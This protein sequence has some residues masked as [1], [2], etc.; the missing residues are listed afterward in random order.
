MN[1][2]PDS[3]DNG[4]LTAIASIFNKNPSSILNDALTTYIAL[5]MPLRLKD[6]K[7]TGNVTGGSI[8]LLK[9]G[10]IGV[11]SIPSRVNNLFD[12]YNSEMINSEIFKYSMILVSTTL[13]GIISGE[14]SEP[15]IRKYLKVLD[16]P[17]L[18][19]VMLQIS[20]RLIGEKL[21]ENGDDISN[22]TLQYML[23]MIKNDKKEIQNMFK[24]ASSDEVA[25][26]KAID[27]YY[28]KL[29]KYFE[30]Y[31][32]R[33]LNMPMED[34]LKIGKESNLVDV[35]GEDNIYLYF[36]YFCHKIK[37]DIYD[38]FK[39]KYQH[40]LVETELNRF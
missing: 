34:A 30:D 12:T 13:E 33:T 11:N 3:L 37:T 15:V 9:K 40:K 16:N 26:E 18:I 35:L 14:H 23:D 31:L 5:H 39:F 25:M 38:K 27:D 2:V 29:N 36:T 22:K 1:S 6:Y 32:N 4:K 21:L 10:R 7:K 24:Q 8:S 17:N 19:F 20:T 28:E